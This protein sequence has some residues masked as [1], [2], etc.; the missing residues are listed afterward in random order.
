MHALEKEV[1]G[2]RKQYSFRVMENF[3][4][5]KHQFSQESSAAFEPLL[6]QSSEQQILQRKVQFPWSKPTSQPQWKFYAFTEHGDSVAAFAPFEFLKWRQTIQLSFSHCPLPMNCP[7]TC[8]HSQA[9]T[10]FIHT[11][12]SELR[13]AFYKCLIIF[14]KTV[15]VNSVWT[16]DN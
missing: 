12:H 1:K 10:L 4:G 15:L 2:I 8:W 14:L 5:S 6:K 11:I 7:S 3:H 9:S 13:P 16:R